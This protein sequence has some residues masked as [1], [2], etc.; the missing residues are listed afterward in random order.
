MKTTSLF[1]PTEIDGIEIFQL[2]EEPIEEEI[3]QDEEL[4][5]NIQ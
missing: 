2:E 3:E 5:E 4:D 1:E